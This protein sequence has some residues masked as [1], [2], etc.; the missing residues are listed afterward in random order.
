MSEKLQETIETEFSE[1]VDREPV[2]SAKNN[3]KWL[4]PIVAVLVIVLT[5]S[6]IS[7]F[8]RKAYKEDLETTVTSIMRYAV[9]AEE[10]ALLIHDVWMNAIYEDRDSRTDKY[11]RPYGYFVSDFNIAL[12]NLFKDDMFS[13][14]TYILNEA[15]ER[16]KSQVLELKD[17]PSGFEE[18]YEACKKL[19]NAYADLTKLGTNP[20]GSLIIYSQ[21]I[22]STVDKVE[23]CY[24]EYKALANE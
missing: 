24:L 12:T 1:S 16:M 4:L 13:A 7:S 2:A 10:G 8:K 23:D 21:A 20:T 9:E 17:V 5:I 19:Y 3:K 18:E 6:I 22:E 15:A 11:T 14:K